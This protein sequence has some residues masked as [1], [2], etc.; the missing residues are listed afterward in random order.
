MPYVCDQIADEPG[1]CSKCEMNFKEVSLEDAQKA[2]NK[3]S[4]A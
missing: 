1:K 3:K 2:M 4:H